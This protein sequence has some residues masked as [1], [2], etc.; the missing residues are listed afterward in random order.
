MVKGKERRFIVQPG[1]QREK[2]QSKHFS[3]SSAICGIQMR[4]IGFN[5]Q[6][7]LII[8]PFFSLFFGSQLEFSLR[9]KTDSIC[10]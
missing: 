9:D 2:R 7:K 1:T 3:P 5:R 8:L 10:A 6:R 4:A